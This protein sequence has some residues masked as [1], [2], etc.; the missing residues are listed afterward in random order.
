MFVSESCGGLI[1]SHNGT[2]TSP[3]FPELYPINKTCTWE[4][5]AE[6]NYVV[7]LNFTHFDL[8]GNNIDMQDCEYD[9]VEVY[10]S[11][12][13]NKRKKHGIF[14]GTNLP[15]II[16]SE[17]NILNVKFKSDSNIQKSGFAAV[18]YMGKCTL[19]F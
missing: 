1:Q 15:K 6:P 4:I 18:F 9:R 11:L 8:E 13:N 19:R 16:T 14:C 2:L 17:E 12:R 5:R 10:S 3:L 7:F